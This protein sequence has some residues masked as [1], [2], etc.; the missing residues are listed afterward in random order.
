MKNTMIKRTSFI[1]SAGLLGLVLFFVITCEQKVSSPKTV[2]TF[3]YSRQVR[4]FINKP[5][6][7]SFIGLKGQAPETITLT[8]NTSH[9]AGG[10]NR[11][12]Y[13]ADKDFSILITIDEISPDSI[14]STA[15]G[16]PITKTYLIKDLSA[17][18]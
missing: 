17:E 9:R 16:I 14:F 6:G 5:D 11:I 8:T 3:S 18:Y 1:L 4:S 12:A 2:G 10:G 15:F 7:V 13:A